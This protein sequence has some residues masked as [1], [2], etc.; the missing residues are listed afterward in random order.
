MGIPEAW[1]D[2][3]RGKVKGTGIRGAWCSE[4]KPLENYGLRS[5]HLIQVLIGS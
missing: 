4:W 2:R 1:L 3:S 5:S